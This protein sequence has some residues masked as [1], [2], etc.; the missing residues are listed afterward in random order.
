MIMG[1]LYRVGQ[2]EGDSGMVSTG[3]GM[4]EGAV[5]CVGAKVLETGKGRSKSCRVQECSLADASA[6]SLRAA[7]VCGSVLKLEDTNRKTLLRQVLP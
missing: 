2:R 7:R 6:S 3:H 4:E 5:N 1:A